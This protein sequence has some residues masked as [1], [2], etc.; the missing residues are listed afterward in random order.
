MQISQD[1]CWRFGLVW[2][3]RNATEG[4]PYSASG[5]CSVGGE[6]AAKKGKCDRGE[7]GDNR[8][9]AEKHARREHGVIE[10]GK[11]NVEEVRQRVRHQKTGCDEAFHVFRSCGV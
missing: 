2:G 10:L 5:L 1:P 9:H 7:K 6:S 3:A 4:V 8:R 11:P